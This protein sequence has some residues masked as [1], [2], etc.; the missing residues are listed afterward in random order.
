MALTDD[1]IRTTVAAIREVL[2]RQLL[3]DD[4]QVDILIGVVAV[5]AVAAGLTDNDVVPRFVRLYAVIKDDIERVI[6]REAAH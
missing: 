3:D 5:A 1:E 6:G 4:D 2:S